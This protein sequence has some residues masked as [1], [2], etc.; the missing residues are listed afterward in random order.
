MNTDQWLD[1]ARNRREWALR[2]RGGSTVGRRL[3]R[4]ILAL[5]LG[6][7]VGVAICLG[8]MLAAL[9]VATAAMDGA[10]AWLCAG[11]GR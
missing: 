3:W 10:H 6:R 7:A 1:D 9:W 11:G 5:W 2:D 4:H 8:V